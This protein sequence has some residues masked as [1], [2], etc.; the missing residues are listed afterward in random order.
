M[1]GKQIGDEKGTDLFSVFTMIR[2]PQYEEA[3][4]DHQIDEV[5]K[6]HFI[7]ADAYTQEENP[8]K[9]FIGYSGL[10]IRG[11]FERGFGDSYEDTLWYDF[12]DAFRDFLRGGFECGFGDDLERGFGN[13][14]EHTG[15]SPTYQTLRGR[16]PLEP[17]SSRDFG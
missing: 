13:G 15:T 9:F 7:N 14:F 16:S 6:E 4:N 17:P 8:S 2:T 11:G 1:F 10:V 5:I 3:L 12:R